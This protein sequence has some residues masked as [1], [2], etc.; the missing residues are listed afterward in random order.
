MAN[1]LWYYTSTH[2]MG[3]GCCHERVVEY[4]L[5]DESG[6]VLTRNDCGPVVEDEAE[7]REVFCY[8]ADDYG[9]FVVSEDSVYI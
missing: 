2:D 1:V 3:C 4:E 7:L 5:R 6:N 8:L 9:D